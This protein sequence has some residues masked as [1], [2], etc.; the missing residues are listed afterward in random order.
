MS[1]SWI[2]HYSASVVY[3]LYDTLFDLYFPNLPLQII[4]SQCEDISVGKRPHTYLATCAFVIEGAESDGGEEDGNV[5][6]DGCGHV[7]QQGFITANYTWG[8]TNTWVIFNSKWS[9]GGFKHFHFK[10]PKTE[11][12]IRCLYISNIQYVQWNYYKRPY[13]TLHYIS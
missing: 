10:T 11:F 6:E 1:Y 7:L 4:N 5:E 3:P 12:I 13:I 2:T 8:E 9:G